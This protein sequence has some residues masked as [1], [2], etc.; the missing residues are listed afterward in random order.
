M[1]NKRKENSILSFF[2]KKI[3]PLPESDVPLPQRDTDETVLQRRRNRSGLCGGEGHGHFWGLNMRHE[4]IYFIGRDSRTGF[5]RTRLIICNRILRDI[6]CV[7][8]SN[9]KN[10]EDGSQNHLIT[11]NIHRVTK[12]FITHDNE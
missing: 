10:Y 2:Q 5:G 3:K 12:V 11:P 4:N 9:D 8:R 1:S 7:P 6:F